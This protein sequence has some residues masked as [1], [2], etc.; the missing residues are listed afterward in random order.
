MHA[1]EAF[2]TIYPS[3]TEEDE[4][5]GRAEFHARNFVRVAKARRCCLE[6]RTMLPH[7]PESDPFSASPCH[8]RNAFPMPTRRL[9]AWLTSYTFSWDREHS[10]SF[11]ALC[12]GQAFPITEKLRPPALPPPKALESDNP[13]ISLTNYEGQARCDDLV[14]VRTESSNLMA[15]RG[16]E[17]ER[18]A[19]RVAGSRGSGCGRDLGPGVERIAAHLCRA[20]EHNEMEERD[21]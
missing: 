11:T 15:R 9:C 12:H 8:F 10:I 3:G 16:R 17:T 13:M 14:L 20:R 18:T 2:L 21:R 4:T 1:T 6:K 7:I 19:S 5:D